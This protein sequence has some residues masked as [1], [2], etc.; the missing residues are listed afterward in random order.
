MS[1]EC[2]FCGAP[3][4]LT[5]EHV[6]P[7]WL[8]TFPAY[9]TLRELNPDR[10]VNQSV[11]T[12]YSRDTTGRLQIQTQV[13]KRVDLLP[14]VTVK[15]VCAA[16]N[17]GWMSKLETSTSAILE[18]TLRTGNRIHLSKEDQAIISRW[19]M[20]TFLM[21]AQYFPRSEIAFSEDDYHSFYK[22]ASIPFTSE[23]WICTSH[24]PYAQVGA[25]YY[26]WLVTFG[27]I[28]ED[29]P[30]TGRPSVAFMTLALHCTTIAMCYGNDSIP[31]DFLDSVFDPFNQGMS[32]IHP[33]RDSTEWP[34]PNLS[35][36]DYE[37]MLKYAP[38]LIKSVSLQSE[39]L[40][41]DES[42]EL[43]ERFLDGEDPS[44]ICDDGRSS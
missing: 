35:D 40:T 5:K 15:C 30:L 32:R 18:Q 12:E 11:P 43:R 29:D 22:S 44:K 27:E 36:S 38:S 16:C 42:R 41:L 6:W 10:K 31:F 33:Y 3:G 8:R 39:G 37:Q 21:Y 7:Q 4:P 20:K 14:D 2:V 26:P 17:N 23:I 28:G 13:R 25:S 1:R 19:G 24:S 34:A 9:E